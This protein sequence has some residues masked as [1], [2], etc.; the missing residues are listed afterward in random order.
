MGR[1]VTTGAGGLG[2]EPDAAPFSL[3][4]PQ[5][6][7]GVLVLHGFTGSP[8]EMRLLGEFLA[9]RGWAVE[10]PCL[11][12]HGG[13]TADLAA[14]GW[15]DWVESADRALNQLRGRAQKIVV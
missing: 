14:T 1:S 12:G 6:E 7:A 5:A 4:P 10:G 15:S 9:G 8:F 11:A 13:T 2:H 3:G